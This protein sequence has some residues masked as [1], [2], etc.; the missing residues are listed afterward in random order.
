MKLVLTHYVDSAP[1]TVDRNLSHHIAAA[2]DDA[3]TRVGGERVDTRTEAIESGLRV[4]AGF[5]V[6]DGSEIRVSGTDRLTTVE[7]AVPWSGTDAQSHKLWAANRFASSMADR[8]L[9]AA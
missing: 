5:D 1:G 8:V 9:A 3:A 2:L 4:T 6:L 7:I